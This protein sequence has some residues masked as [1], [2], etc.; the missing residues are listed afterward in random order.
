M[1]FLIIPLAHTLKQMASEMWPGHEHCPVV[2]LWSATSWNEFTA[3]EQSRWAGAS[4][5]LTS[6]KPL[7]TQEHQVSEQLMIFMLYL[8]QTVTA[9]LYTCTSWSHSE[10]HQLPDLRVWAVT[11]PWHSI[12]SRCLIQG[13]TQ[14]VK[15]LI[16]LSTLSFFNVTV[17]FNFWKL[18]VIDV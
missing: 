9:T 1:V 7:Q 13:I 11:L 16:C 14:K 18:K 8:V 15:V 10:P 5:P 4:Q 6:K 2:E 3:S 12:H 17:C